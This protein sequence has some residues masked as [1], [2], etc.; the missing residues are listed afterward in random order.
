MELQKI[1]RQAYVDELIRG[2]RS[3][4]LASLYTNESFDYDEGKVLFTP[5]ITKPKNG[6]LQL[7]DESDNYDFENA[8]IIY[9]AYPALTPLQA[10]DIR[11]W[12]YLAHADYYKYMKKRWPNVNDVEGNSKYI[13]DHWFITSA[14]QNSFLR[15]GL[16]G[17]WWGAHLSCDE[18]REDKYELTRVLFRQLDFVS[19][20]LGAYNLSR[21][22]EAVI[23]ILDYILQNP[24]LFGKHFQERTRF[25]TKYFNQIGGTKPISFFDR[26]FFKSALQTAED[27][28]SKL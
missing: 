27:R 12:T 23:G 11:L 2:V 10:S 28:I 18:T 6:E 24:E 9:E 1:F 26:D 7:P 22:K 16:A 3:G 5:E 21:H 25:L 19:R 4:F 20:T 8:R 13:L 17:L 14:T 15:H